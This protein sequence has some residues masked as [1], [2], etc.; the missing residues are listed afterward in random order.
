MTEAGNVAFR[1]YYSKPYL[2]MP[3]SC[4]AEPFKYYSDWD[5]IFDVERPNHSLAS[6][7]RKVM[8]PPI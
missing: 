6:A 3:E 8:P 7:M 4:N 5:S 1:K 2:D